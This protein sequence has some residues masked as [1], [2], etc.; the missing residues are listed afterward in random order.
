MKA[1]VERCGAILIV[2]NLPWGSSI[3]PDILEDTLKQ[4]SDATLVASFM[5]KHLPVQKVI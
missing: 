5:L 2:I 4:N 3:D 1:I